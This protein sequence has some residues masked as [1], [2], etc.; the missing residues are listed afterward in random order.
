MD[1]LS[2]FFRSKPDLPESTRQALADWA[3]LPFVPAQERLV[4]VDVEATGLDPNRDHLLA[5]AAVSVCNGRIDLA[6][7]F[8]TVIRQEQASSKES[9]VRTGIGA[10]AQTEGVPPEQALL[11]F[12]AYL[13]KAPL[14]AFNV[15]FC[16][17]ILKRAFDGALG[18]DFVH[19]WL[20]MAY[21]LPGLYPEIGKPRP[22][23][24]DWMAW[25]NIR[26]FGRH[27]AMSD[28]IVTAEAY[29]ALQGRARERDA[30]GFGKLKEIEKAKR[31]AQWAT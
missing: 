4:F 25:F 6:D 7:S 20:D 19:E 15:G 30:V 28:A 11:A 18:L 2:R 31:W 13:G 24:D 14:A 1:F 17:A 21:L 5:I 10:K 26:G 8:E 22:S 29:L 23:L 16:E 27:H 3:A 12:L 9:I